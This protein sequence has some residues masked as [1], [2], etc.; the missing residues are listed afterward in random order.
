MTMRMGQRP[1]QEA[2]GTRRTK[3]S[4]PVSDRWC[5]EHCLLFARTPKRRVIKRENNP[6]EDKDTGSRTVSNSVKVK[7]NNLVNSVPSHCN[8]VSV[9]MCME[10]VIFSSTNQYK[11]HEKCLK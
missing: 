2:K 1:H 11:D 10:Y 8:F 3:T 7:P 9:S 5:M 4:V 6:D